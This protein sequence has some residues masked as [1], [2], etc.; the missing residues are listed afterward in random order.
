MMKKFNIIIEETVVQIFEVEADN[1]KEALK[2]ALKKYQ[3][4]EFILDNCECQDVKIFASDLSET[5]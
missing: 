1:E 5:V 2:T 3:N 4:Q